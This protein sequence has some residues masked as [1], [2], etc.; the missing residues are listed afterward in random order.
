MKEALYYQTR[1]IK[2]VK[3]LLCPHTCEIEDS[4]TGI[5]RIRRNINGRLEAESYEIVSALHVDPIEKKPLY[6]FYPGKNIL[7]VGGYGCNFSCSFCQNH[8]IS[9]RNS[10]KGNIISVQNIMNKA[11]NTIDNIGIAYTYNEPTVWYEFMLDLAIEVKKHNLKNV[12]VTNGYIN[13]EPLNKLLDYIDAVNI[14]LKAFTNNFYRELTNG[15]IEP[16]KNTIRALYNKNVHFEITYL[17]ITSMNDYKENFSDMINWINNEFGP[18]IVLHLS[19]YFPNYRFHQEPSSLKT[20]NRFYEIAS[21]KLNYVYLGNVSTGRK[22]SDTQCPECGQ[23]II[24]RTGYYTSL[25][26]LSSSGSCKYC[27]HRIVIS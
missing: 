8:D 23:I 2:K 6:H 1:D 26:G 17:V 22:G 12:L 15:S 5:C 11:L 4:E 19:R 24:K 18:N 10:E 7:S 20:L 13:P 16:V 27:N 14:D 9:Q 25:N 3:C 21:D